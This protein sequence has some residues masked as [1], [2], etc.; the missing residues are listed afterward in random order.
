MMNAVVIW[1][2]FFGNLNLKVFFLMISELLFESIV[3]LKYL[4]IEVQRVT[5]GY[6][7]VRQGTAGH[8]RL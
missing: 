3:N 4:E 2:K 6:G 8:C 7:R 1:G 5:A